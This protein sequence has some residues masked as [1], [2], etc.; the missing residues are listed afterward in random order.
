MWLLVLAQFS[1]AKN[2]ISAREVARA[3]EITEESAWHMVH[4]I[5][6]AMR[7]EPVVGLFSGVVTVGDETFIGGKPKN[8]HRSKRHAKDHDGR[9]NKTAVLSLVHR[10]T[11][12][13]EFSRSFLTRAEA[14]KA[15]IEKHVDLPA[16]VLHTDSAPVYVKI[17]WKAQDHQSVNHIMGEYVRGAVTTN[18]A[19]GY[20]AQL[21][22]SIAGTFHNVSVQHLPRVPGRVCF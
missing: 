19:E 13:V 18:H 9:D 8:M 6:E 2:G 16:T 10:E 11:G 15:A 21:K 20:F 7:R 14:L 1:S 12:E 5:R 4:R 22:G 17:G 3:H